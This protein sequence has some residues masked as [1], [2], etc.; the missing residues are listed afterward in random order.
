[1]LRRMLFVTWAP[2]FG[3]QTFNGPFSAVSRPIFCDQI[4]VGKLLTRSTI[5]YEFHIL[6][7]NLTFKFSQIF[8]KTFS[9]KLSKIVTIVCRQSRLS[10]FATAQQTTTT[11]NNNRLALRMLP[12][13]NLRI[14][15]NFQ[16]MQ[17]LSVKS[18]N[19]R[20]Y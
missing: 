16:K 14:S 18:T 8:V 11:D 5:S 10:W 4:R 3:F 6:I 7:V 1:M 17:L 9:K 12:F 15:R 19:R 20:N 2:I 13:K